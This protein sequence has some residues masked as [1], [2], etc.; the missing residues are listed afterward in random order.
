MA[1][2]AIKL[3]AAGGGV[4]ASL[5]DAIMALSP[6]GYWKLDETSGSTAVDS[7]GN[8]RDG[9]YN[10]SITLAGKAGA[11]GGDYADFPGTESDR[12]TVPAFTPSYITTNGSVTMFGLTY[13]DSTAGGVV[14]LPWMSLLDDVS[15]STRYHWACTVKPN[16]A[17]E[18]F[19]CNANFSEYRIS[20]TATSLYST[21]QWTA[22][23]ATFDTTSVS[24]ADRVFLDSGTGISTTPSTGGS[25]VAHSSTAILGIGGR[26]DANPASDQWWNGGLAHCALFS[27]GISDAEVQDL[28]DAAASEG[29]I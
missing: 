18:V 3:L 8:G 28:M 5:P 16:G 7:S 24:T 9:T 27:P 15:G 25:S 14:V 21:G 12:V 11:D 19:K 6:Q 4:V 13:V 26:A 22:L 29:W 10:G 2:P 23:A 20:T 17:L 1:S